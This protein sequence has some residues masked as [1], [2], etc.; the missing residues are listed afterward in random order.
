MQYRD[1]QTY[2]IDSLFHYFESGK[3]GN[4][5][6]AMP[7]GTGKSVVI[8]GFIKEAMNRFPNQ[9]IV[10]LT[11]VKELIRQNFDK[12]LKLWPLAPAG[13]YSAGLNRKDLH[14]PITYAGVASIAN[15]IE[16]LGHVDLLIVD[17]CHLV[18]NDQDSMYMEIWKQLKSRNPYIKAIGLSATPYRTG[19]GYIIGEDHLFDEICID[20]TSL[21][22]FNWFFEEGYLCPL[23]PKPTGV[24]LDP[25]GIKLQAG[26][27]NIGQQQIAFDKEELTHN[28]LQE[29]LRYGEDR[30][31]WLIFATGVEH[32]VHTAEALNQLGIPTTYVH[33]KMTR[34]ER[35]TRLTEYESGK[36]RAMVNN[37]ILTTGYDFPAIDLIAVIRLTNSAGLWV[38]IL[39]RGIRPVYAAGYDLQT[40]EGRRAAIAAS[41]KQNCLV[42]DF[43]RNTERL[44][45]INDPTLPKKKGQ[46]V[47]RGAPYRVCEH[48]M[49]YNHAGARF[50]ISCGY[51]FPRTV[52]FEGSSGTDEL[53]RKAIPERVIKTF[54]I[55]QVIYAR[56]QK[57]GGRASLR[58]SY[59]C[60]RRMFQEWICLEHD[61]FPK[62]KAQKWWVERATTQPPET[63]D[64][65]MARVKELK[66]P[67]KIDVCT[68][69]T[70]PEVV[71]YYYAEEESS[72]V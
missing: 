27:Y 21:E 56:H 70:Y 11:H 62:R 57:Q 26:E 9:R 31:H 47:G 41:Q 55:T 12:L 39:G 45:P 42:L 20:M 16:E 51:E 24:Y 33:S 23:I 48:C 17:E 30:H 1:Y 13:V 4:P 22:P 68:S 61:N 5:I 19:S 2:A 3:T 35:D 15:A 65:A 14:Y 53:I 18:S 60:G 38:Q 54:D 66:M 49:T 69:I 64:A 37:G 44:G 25:A 34:N 43:A 58:V 72:T 50:C 59:L 32:T 7:P 40:K 71:G 67:I 8:G 29:I 10:M 36:Y 63:I 6:I 28:A 46:A 52:K